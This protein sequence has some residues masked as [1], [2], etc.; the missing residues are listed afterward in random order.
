VAAPRTAPTAPRPVT[1]RPAAPR[2]GGSRPAEPE[3]T[4]RRSSGAARSVA[5]ALSPSAGN[6]TPFIVLLCGLLGGAL[7]S[8][9]V[10]NTTLA[11][12]SFEINKLQMSDSAL[13][14]QRQQ[15]QDQV[16]QAQSAQVIEQRAAELGMRPQGQLQFVNLK[17]GKIETD[18]GS[19][20]TTGTSGSAP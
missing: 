6:R 1:P 12:G 13:A 14:R 3:T 17:T 4:P 16:A 2:P 9:L 7:V 8:A 15:L 11:E 18:A 5:T 10:I 19:G 20:T